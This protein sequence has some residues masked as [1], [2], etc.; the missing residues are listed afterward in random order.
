MG[1]VHPATDYFDAYYQHHHFRSL[2]DNEAKFNYVVLLINN[3]AEHCRAQVS[4][5]EETAIYAIQTGTILLMEDNRSCWDCQQPGHLAGSPQ[6]KK[7]S[8]KT[9]APLAQQQAHAAARVVTGPAS[10]SQLQ[11]R[12]MQAGATCALAMSG[13]AQEQAPPPFSSWLHPY[14]G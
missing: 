9:K 12:Q 6:C 3:A 2:M 10:R 8:E 1:K 7:P 4:P 5:Q 13:P 11:S 14:Q